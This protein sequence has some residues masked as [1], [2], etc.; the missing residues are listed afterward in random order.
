MILCVA[1]PFPLRLEHR[2]YSGDNSLGSTRVLRGKH[3]TFSAAVH[4]IRI[5]LVKQTENSGNFL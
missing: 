2:G 1:D 4:M 3:T 5:C